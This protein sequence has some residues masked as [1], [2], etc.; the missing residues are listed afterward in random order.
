MCLYFF[1]VGIG[2]V[3]VLVGCV[4]SGGL[5]ICGMLIDLFMLVIM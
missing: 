2:F 4:S 3:F 5:Y 1:V